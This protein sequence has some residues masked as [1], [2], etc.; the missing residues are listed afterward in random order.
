MN[1]TIVITGATTGIGAALREQLQAS[2]DTVI[3]VDIRDAD[4]VADLTTAEGRQLA[5]AAIRARCPDGI[6]GFVP[7]AGLGP[8]YPSLSRITSLNFFAVRELTECLLPLLKLANGH[9]VLVASN[10]AS[11]PGI[12]QD[13]VQAMLGNN[14]ILTCE[15]VEKLDGFQAYGGSKQALVR[16]MRKLTP[17]WAKEG[18]RINA[19]APGT[20]QTPLLQAGLDDPLWGDAIRNF[21]VPLGGFADPAQIASALAFFLGNDA[22]F[23]TGSVLF[24]DGGTDALMRPDQF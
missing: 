7:C 19:V 14:E 1:R 11:L 24:V 21:P 13:L 5:L 23:C 16:W 20:T 18:V 8:Q 9:V 10:S 6:N 17:V 22:S 15:L 4:I 3:N 2:G 12:N